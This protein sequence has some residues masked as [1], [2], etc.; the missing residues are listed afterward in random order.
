MD[1]ELQFTTTRNLDPSDLFKRHSSLRSE[2]IFFSQFCTVYGCCFILEIFK[3]LPELWKLLRVPLF[4]S[5]SE[6]FQ[7]CQNNS[8]WMFSNSLLISRSL[9]IFDTEISTKV[10]ENNCEKCQGYNILI[11]SKNFP[12]NSRVKALRNVRVTISW[13]F[14]EFFSFS[15]PEKSNKVPDKKLWEMS[16]LWYPDNFCEFSQHF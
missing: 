5:F 7:N 16:G 11:I 4:W 12:R 2:C 9:L 15:G 6:N 13:S 8:L 3:K 14:P 10:P 1:A